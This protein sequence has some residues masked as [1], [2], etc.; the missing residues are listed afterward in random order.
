MESHCAREFRLPSQK[1]IANDKKTQLLSL[2][3]FKYTSSAQKFVSTVYE[4]FSSKSKSFYKQSIHKL[5]KRW[6]LVIDNVGKYIIDWLN[7]LCVLYTFQDEKYTW[8]YG[9]T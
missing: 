9:L 1:V 6:K 4:Y 7:M 8:T 3:K 5:L 2:N